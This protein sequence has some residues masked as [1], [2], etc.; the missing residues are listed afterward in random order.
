MI[1]HER[2]SKVS[3]VIQETLSS[4][5]TVQAFARE[6]DEIKRFTGIAS[7]SAEA[8]LR[9]TREQVMFGFVAGMITAAGMAAMIGIAGYRVLMGELTVGRL[10]V[11]ITY[12]GMLYGPMST[13]SNLSASIQSAIAPFNRVVEFLRAN[14]VIRDLPKARPLVEC[15]GVVRFENVT[16]G[17]DE[18]KPVLKDLD[19]EARPGQTIAL[20]GATGSGKS[21]L[22][23][24]L[25]RFYDPQGGRVLVDGVDV[26]EFQYRSLRKKIA[27][28]PQEPVL[29]SSS[30]REN[31][32]YGRPNA[33]LEQIVAAAKQAEAH[34]FISA[35]ENGYETTIGERGSTLSGGQRQRLA[36][37]RAF[38]KDSPILILDEPTAALDTETEAAVLTAL[39][40]LR[41]GRTVL[42]VAHRLVTVRDATEVFVME[43]GRIAERGT[44]DQLLARQGH[45]AR[46]VQL[47]FSDETKS[48]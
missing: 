22:L 25:L 10:F 31:I 23:S 42:I 13:I 30:V 9:M 15:R 17:Y 34:E 1:F 39:R 8:N 12:V 44:H 18:A 36:L 2:E 37:A 4:I 45:Y 20:V 40:R 6:D 46:L 32:A 16:F 28:V 38:L 14:L 26:R 11:F 7:E 3:S 19:F 35:M 29:F 43:D 48:A 33:T 5:R 21:T 24:L 27:V 41:E 47:Q